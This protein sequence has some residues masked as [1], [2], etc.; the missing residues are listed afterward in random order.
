MTERAAT[1]HLA[2]RRR[3]AKAALLL[4]ALLLVTWG[5]RAWYTGYVGA[6]A[7][8]Q[9]RAEVRAALDYAQAQFTT[10]QQRLVRRAEALAR[11]PAVVGGL[12][13]RRGGNLES[14]TDALVERFAALETPRRV[15]VELYDPA[16]QLIAW[17]GYSVPLDRVPD[18]LRAFEAAQITLAADANLRRALV[19]WV[20]VQDSTTRVL[21]AVR[22]MRLVDFAAPVQNQ[23]IQSFSLSEDWSE[24]T[25]LL[26]RV[27]LGPE[28]LLGAE[29][30]DEA[31]P[32]AAD[33][34]DPVAGRARALTS[35]SGEVIGRVSV[36]PPSAG[37]LIE[38]VAGRFSGVMAL[39]ATLL[40]V[41][42]MVEAWRW[43]RA[44]Y[45]A[46][47]GGAVH[48]NLQRLAA[49]FAL[50]G[51]S[52]WG[53]RYALIAL[54]V[55]A[56]W[57]SSGSP[58][59]P[60]F[61]PT[62][63]ASSIGAGLMRSA[64]DLLI[65]GGFAFAFAVAFAEVA[66]RFRDKGF[67]LLRLREALS[68]R[69]ARTEEPRAKLEGRPSP[70]RFF[71][72]LVGVTVIAKGLT[73]LLAVMAR[74]AVLDSTLDFFERT[75]FFPQPLVLVVLCALLLLT[76]AAV[77][78][79]AGLA[80]TALWLL[81]RY[82]PV[83][84]PRAA[85]AVGTL[86]AV[87]VPLV[88]FYVV[89]GMEAV[90]AWPVSLGFLVASASTAAFG[91]ARRSGGWE[92]LTLHRLLPSVLL[93]TLLVY[94]LLYAGMDAQRRDR[95]LDAAASFGQGR[96]PRVLFSIEEALEELSTAPVL[97][98]LLSH[99]ADLVQR[100]VFERLTDNL[101]DETLL[102]SL[103]TYRVTVSLFGPEGEA[104]GRYA[105][106]GPAVDHAAGPADADT[107]EFDV[108]RK[109]YAERGASG[110]MIER[111]TSQREESRFQ[112]AGLAPVRPAP[113]GARA[114]VRPRRRAGPRRT[115]EPSGW[116]VVSAEPQAVLPEAGTPFPRVL[117]PAGYYADGQAGLSLAEFRDGRLVR[118][119]GRDFGR[120]RL[121]EDTRQALG[122]EPALWGVE[123]VKGRSYLTLYRQQA[124]RTPPEEA[125]QA[126]QPVSASVVAARV[127]AI[128]TFDHLY[129][130]LRL[131][132]AGLCIGLPL[133][134]VGLFFR[135]WKGLLPAPRLRFRDKM[136]NAFLL[137]GA[138]S[139][140]VVGFV[141]LRV[142]TAENE[143]ATE[144]WLRE[145]LEQAEEVLAF[146]AEPGEPIYRV[147]ERIGIDSLA[148]RMGLD[149]NLYQ[150]ARLVESSRPR[151]VRER[152][153]DERLPAPAYA[154]LYLDG[155]RFTTTS[156]W[157]GR[158]PYAAG[159]WALTDEAGAPRYVLSAP[160][161][162]EQERIEEEQARTVA[163]LFGA[164][165]LLIVIVMLTA[166]LLA[167]ALARPIVR[168]RAELEAV[169]RGEFARALPVTTRDEIGEL[170]ATFN[171]MRAQLAE[172]RRKLAQQEREVAWREMARQVAHEIKNPLTPMKLSVQ[173]L[174]RAYDRL[175][176]PEGAAPG[177]A[178][179]PLQEAKP[180]EE[181]GRFRTLFERITTTLVEQIDTLARIANEFSSF[182][183]LPTRVLEPLDLNEVIHEA[184]ALMQEEADAEIACDFHPEPL[185]V[186]ADQEELRRVYIN[187][188]KNALQA[189]PKDG[190][191][192]V[193]VRTQRSGLEGASSNGQPPNG[194]TGAE[195]AA[196]QAQAFV[197]DNG[198]GIP[199]ELRSKIFQP[200]FSTKT[201][202][203]GLGLAIAR[204]SIEEMNGAIGFET[205]EGR[206]TTF[207]IRLP[208]IPVE[209]AEEAAP[210]DE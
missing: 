161:L 201:S 208:L 116:I 135:H 145:R 106:L 122:A 43:Y 121:A 133:Y 40:L 100:Q 15:A 88:L 73:W 25:G 5:A 123:N 54:D 11:D 78:V 77:L 46:A 90:I 120:Y 169:G 186:E 42:L 53:L 203:T 196:P 91:F 194:R 111:I 146:E 18:S 28:D 206:G 41:L 68:A 127:P 138:V 34:A 157:V 195:A 185:V 58:L 144:R 160:T 33:E 17:S 139:V 50:I 74:Q 137:V 95:L 6:H 31:A 27:T 207:W 168:L 55:P 30:E 89:S 84:W 102:T 163:Y 200:N 26:M 80:W 118:S 170:V 32:S 101:L 197:I 61:D 82:W 39:W 56:R 150:G 60:L 72:V 158:F 119:F 173:H 167:G 136:L 184:V 36:V 9:Q 97:R 177:Q 143:Q 172:S 7:E 104:L 10:L 191:G 189:L 142:L 49:R 96:D 66:A 81:M 16:L 21:G 64:G 125:F 1:Y 205:E 171:E 107:G 2:R 198:M 4:V 131:T 86:V 162:P 175:E 180:D 93:L 3:L 154:A 37:Q 57:I 24:A 20:P 110:A 48:K 126:G 69:L 124:A 87:G 174:R 109:M 38:Q 98:A 114:P 141:G 92:L 63:L 44:A 65:T 22:A 134:V 209:R 75:G 67:G 129:Y 204:K 113:E 128:V 45:H 187:L 112:Y 108:L 85:V 164:L 76:I 179:P 166:A 193:T 210:A 155:L 178:A 70:T 35:L 105:V 188:I 117:L 52:W 13:Q 140:V 29:E 115:P 165:L 153:I 19:A 79:I 62:H 190:A 12:E 147:A 132:L 156:E 47:S 192:R 159:F 148:A 14:S 176:V 151:L 149:L 59:A 103:G 51:L 182:A 181:A 83:A 8:A 94:P 183:R 199:P 71:A 152:L 99:E 130:L 23:Y 202:G